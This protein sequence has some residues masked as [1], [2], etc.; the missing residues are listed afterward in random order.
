MQKEF[1]S[2]KNQFVLHVRNFDLILIFFLIKP[3]FAAPCVIPSTENG[4]Y[5]S[6]NRP[7]SA[8]TLNPGDQVVANGVAYFQCNEG[9]NVQGLTTLRCNNGEWLPAVM[10]ECVPKPCILPRLDM[11]N[12]QGGY[13]S[14]LTIAHGSSVD[15]QCSLLIG[16]TKTP[17]RLDCNLGKLQPENFFCRAN[18]ALLNSGLP[19][20]V[21]VLNNM[22]AMHEVKDNDTTKMCGVPEK[23][24]EYL[25]Y[26]RDTENEIISKEG[27]FIAGTEIQFSCISS[28]TGERKTWKIVCDNG[29]WVGR[30][31]ECGKV[32]LLPAPKSNFNF[33]QLFPEEDEIEKENFILLNGSCI[34]RNID[35]HVVSFYNDLEIREEYVE[36][37]PDSVIVAR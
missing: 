23:L 1:G 33:F 29:V 21:T 24:N 18:E 20:T 34:F 8:Q 16:G 5:V 36:F 22:T 37:P 28:G 25:T 17:H 15:I 4:K 35:P 27:G 30:S 9:Y 3:F 12:Y 32:I 31:T 14:G 10:P 7:E 11:G 2:Q 6:D 13:R 19:E 26:R